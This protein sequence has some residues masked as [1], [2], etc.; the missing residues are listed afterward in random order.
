[1]MGIKS[2]Q[3]MEHLGTYDGYFHIEVIDHPINNEHGPIIYRTKDYF[4]NEINEMFVKDIFEKSFI[5][6]QRGTMANLLGVFEGRKRAYFSESIELSLSEFIKRNE[7]DFTI[8]YECE[9]L[10]NIGDKI[11]LI[12]EGKNK[13]LFT[14]IHNGE[15]I[16]LCEI[17]WLHENLKK[18]NDECQPNSKY[19]EKGFY[20]DFCDEEC[21]RGVLF[22]SY[23]KGFENQQNIMLFDSRC[24]EIQN[25]YLVKRNNELLKLNNNEVNQFA[26][27]DMNNLSISYDYSHAFDN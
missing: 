15:Y 12:K 9:L 22:S 8:V 6:D 26:I 19:S 16:D 23:K 27:F 3:A 24:I 10:P 4:K 14:K 7:T 18:A 25:V 20:E 17:N 11:H 1:M 21:I 5:N 13:E 2:R